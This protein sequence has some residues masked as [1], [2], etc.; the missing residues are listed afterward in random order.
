MES[1]RQLGFCLQNSMDLRHCV[2]DFAKLQPFVLAREELLL[3][4]VP[5]KKWHHF[6][7]VDPLIL[8]ALLKAL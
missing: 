7:C 2:V 4:G 1:Q 8:E 3:R 5:S 6:V